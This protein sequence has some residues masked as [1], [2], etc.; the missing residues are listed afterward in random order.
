MT[1][2]TRPTPR[3]RR[4]DLRT[5][6]QEARRGCPA[7]MVE[8][9]ARGDGIGDGRGEAEADAVGEHGLLIGELR[10]W[11]LVRGVGGPKHRDKTGVGRAEAQQQQRLRRGLV[12]VVGQP[13]RDERRAQNQHDPAESESRRQEGSPD[14]C[15]REQDRGEHKRQVRQNAAK[16]HGGASQNAE[17]QDDEPGATPRRNSDQG[18]RQHA[19]GERDAEL[20]ITERNDR[21]GNRIHHADQGV[22]PGPGDGWLTRRCFGVRGYP[23]ILLRT[24]SLDRARRGRRA[25]LIAWCP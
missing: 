11:S 15:G 18:R 3:L 23:V 6:D 25:G 7:R 16:E 13:D 1:D 12:I 19:D 8:S 22:W 21:G 17:D 20:R 5:G 4:R 9:H 24:T 2:A 14:D 10:L